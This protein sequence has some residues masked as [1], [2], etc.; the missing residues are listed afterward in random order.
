MPILKS[1]KINPYRDD[2]EKTVE[3]SPCFD[4]SIFCDTELYIEE[5][6]KQSIPFWKAWWKYLKSFFS[7]R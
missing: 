2:L 3:H 4:P 1:S 7:K 6:T 5:K